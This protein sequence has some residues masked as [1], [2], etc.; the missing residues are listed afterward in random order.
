VDVVRALDLTEAAHEL[1]LET[2]LLPHLAH[3][4]LLDAFTRFDPA[5][6]NDGR[7]LRISR[8]VEDEELVGARLGVLAGDVG[9]DGWPGSQLF[10]ARILAL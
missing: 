7:K 6:G 2:C 8:K 10:W 3:R 9:G 4:G 1:D 5:A